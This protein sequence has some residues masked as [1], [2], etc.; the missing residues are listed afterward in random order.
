MKKMVFIQSN[1][2]QYIGAKL[3]K[4]SILKNS[5]SF[6]DEDIQIM[7]VEEYP[8]MMK[9]EGEKYLRKGSLVKWDNNDLQSFTLTRFLPPSLMNFEGQAL[10]I[11]PDVFSVNQSDVSEVFKF[12]ESG[13]KAVY[14]TFDKTKNGVSYRTSVMLLNCEK[15]KHWK[16]NDQLDQLF[17][18]EIDYRDWMSLKLER[19]E[20]I[21]ELPELWN[22]YDNLTPN[23]KLIHYTN[24]MTQPWKTNLPIDFQF[25]P[26]QSRIPFL[27][28]RHTLAIKQLINPSKY[29]KTYQKNPHPDQERAFFEILK[30]ALDDGFLDMSDV[31]NEIDM[32]NVRKDI[33]EQVQS[34]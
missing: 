15:L 30:S 16:W 28:T 19:P 26:N 20:T 18:Q 13:D 10:V 17:R 27:T 1:K 11:D 4:Y 3:A 24:R 31:R 12:A 32:G 29:P 21:G 22:H 14:C 9:R 25:D 23:T 6:K 5:P 33:I 2:K 34:I 7:L 8:Y